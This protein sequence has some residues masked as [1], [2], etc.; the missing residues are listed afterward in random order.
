MRR[1]ALLATL[2]ASP[3]LAQGGAQ[4]N[5]PQRS[6][7]LVVPYAAGGPTDRYARE[8]APRLTELWG[9]Q[10]V[11]S[12]KPGGATAIGTAAVAHAAPDGYT[13]L[14]AS[15]GIV[16]NPIM[17]KELP[18]NPRALAP[19]CRV[20]LGGGVLYVH[21]SVPARDMQELVAWAKANPGRL[22]FGSSGMG[23]SPH[24]AAEL[25]AWAAGIE[26]L[27]V[28]YR[29]SG[30][31]L[32]DLI[33]G[34]INALFDST[35]SMRF[36]REGR[37]RAIAIAQPQRNATA[38]EVPT[39]AELGY[40]SVMARTFYG[41]LSPA[42]V[43]AALQERIASDVR[44]VAASERIQRLIREDGLEPVVETPTEFA[45]FLAEQHEF[46]SRVVRE[47]NLAL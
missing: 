15:F 34:H 13:L 11:V 43:P 16:T 10:V 20:A 14:M 45:A 38:P 7:E 30:P 41:F 26:I 36:A 6:V 5:W 18:Y 22:R 46:W 33:A 47:R 42:A 27:H 39:M 32:T 2:L 17:L 19:L 28:P 3:A 8:F 12:N 1:R 35:T 4:P 23:S 29:G 21:P 40:P 25:L 44:G 9:Q 31:A 37:I 24:I